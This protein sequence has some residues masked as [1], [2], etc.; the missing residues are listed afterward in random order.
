MPSDARV[1]ALFTGALINGMFYQTHT[2]LLVEGQVTLGRDGKAANCLQWRRGIIVNT[3][4]MVIHSM[5]ILTPILPRTQR[6]PHLTTSE[7]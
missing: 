3:R 2:E 7:I 5:V 4:G 6:F 1:I